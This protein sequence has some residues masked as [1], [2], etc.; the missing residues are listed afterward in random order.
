MPQHQEKNGDDLSGLDFLRETLLGQQIAEKQDDQTPTNNLAEQIEWVQDELRTQGEEVQQALDYKINEVLQSIQDSQFKKISI[1]NTPPQQPTPPPPITSSPSPIPTS[2]NPP[3]PE[4]A[5][6]NTV[7]RTVKEMVLP[8]QSPEASPILDFDSDEFS[9]QISAILG[10]TSTPAAPPEPPPPIQEV[11]PPVVD[12]PP[13]PVQ[14]VVQPAV[15]LPPPPSI[16]EQE[17]R[18]RQDLR[19][20]LVTEEVVQL[21][22]GN[23]VLDEKLSQMDDYLSSFPQ[24]MQ[25]LLPLMTELVQLKVQ[26]ARSGLPLPTPVPEPVPPTPVIPTAV[27]NGASTYVST[28]GVRRRSM[29]GLLS[30]LLLLLLIPLGFYGYWLWRSR[31]LERDV[32][33]ALNSTPEL[34]L[35]R[36]SPEVKHNT[37]Y[38]TGKVPSQSLS[39]R[40]TEIAQATQ[41]TLTVE[42][43]I[44]VVEALLDPAQMQIEIDKVL[45]PLNAISGIQVRSVLMG[46]R[47]TL[48]GTV[49]KQADIDVVIAAVKK[50]SGISQ[51][52]N[53]IK[54][55]AQPISTQLYFDQNSSAVKSDDLTQKL[56]SV[57]TFL[58]QHPELHLRITGYQ[59]PSESAM[60]VA[61]K[62]AQTTQI[63]LQDQGIDR[64]RIVTL[65]V[66]QSPPNIT[67]S[68]P[69]WLSR[70]VLF[71]IIAPSSTAPATP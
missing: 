46:D 63:L 48:N 30:G 6:D 39:D 67:P 10:E 49:L 19:H 70:T 51:V 4:P 14:T 25:D 26:G 44:L 29:G 62:R 58:K 20:L 33:I 43:H 31:I 34:S 54:I 52:I 21:R 13:P 41:P 71:D 1:P 28:H 7:G 16:S 68:E 61:L 35:Y 22:Q 23:P 32:A 57:K 38:L 8:K 24:S 42:N 47:L 64:R 53:N 36:L 55:E 9:R 45:N 56:E 17:L 5:V 12:V 18:Q 66:N 50:I 15:E 65:G 40:A 11:S 60:D 59:H 3:I 37:L 69:I 27:P 2:Q